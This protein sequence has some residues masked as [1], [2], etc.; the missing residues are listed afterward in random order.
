MVPFSTE[1]NPLMQHGLGPADH[2]SPQFS[3][4]SQWEDVTDNPFFD[5]CTRSRGDTTNTSCSSKNFHASEISPKILDLENEPPRDTKED[6]AS[7]VLKELL[8][9]KNKRGDD[10][11]RWSCLDFSK[12]D[13]RTINS[14]FP[15]K[16]ARF[17]GQF[18]PPCQWRSCAA[19]IVEWRKL[20]KAKQQASIDHGGSPKQSATQPLHRTPMQ[21]LSKNQ[22]VTVSAPRGKND[23]IICEGITMSTILLDRRTG[24]EID[25]AALCKKG[26]HHLVGESIHNFASCL[27]HQLHWPVDSRTFP[28]VLI[29]ECNKKVFALL[30]IRPVYS[31]YLLHE[32]PDDHSDMYCFV[33]PHCKCN[34]P[35]IRQY[36]ETTCS[37]CWDMLKKIRRQCH[38]TSERRSNSSLID[39]RRI[40]YMKS[41]SELY[42]NIAARQKRKVLSD[43]K[44]CALLSRESKKLVEKLPEKALEEKVC[45]ALDLNDINDLFLHEGVTKTVKK[46]EESF[47]QSTTKKKN[48]AKYI[49]EECQIQA[50]QAKKSGKKTC[51]FSPVVF[52]FC[53]EIYVKLGSGRY[54]FVA[55]AFNFPTSRSIQ[56]KLGAAGTNVRD[57]INYSNLEYV[58][59]HLGSDAPVDDVGRLFWLAFDS[60]HFMDGNVKGRH[61]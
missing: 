4:D 58:S 13:I 52:R 19:D 25:D 57:G 39:N 5:D 10:R 3:W 49:W 29:N 21:E 12:V 6:A 27:S 35:K 55:S 45:D 17:G 24:V 22:M 46:M 28:G 7:F 51:R 30:K 23:L 43:I 48:I 11:Q 47:S 31:K 8:C 9:I 33:S 61:V 44:L 2:P 37:G 40:F 18:D 1:A 42:D 34:D 15:K 16:V 36:G 20:S 14:L 50:R 54:D 59:E 38:S 41:P 56:N 60:T 32:L 53:M 26:F